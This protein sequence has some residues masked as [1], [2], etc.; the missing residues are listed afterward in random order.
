MTN[1]IGFPG[2]NLFFKIN[3]IAFYIGEK[4]VYWYGI[5]IAIGFLAAVA[6]V[7]S[8]CEKQGVKRDSIYDIAVWGL[9]FGVLGA[10]IYY[11]IFDFESIK[12]SFLN[13]FKIWNGGIAIYGGIIGACLSSYIYCRR[14]K[15]HTLKVFDVC[16]PGLLIGQIIGR[17][18]NFVNAEVYGKETSV[19]WRMT[20]NGDSGVHPLFLYESL[21]N[22]LGLFVVLTYRKKTDGE[23]FFLYMLWYALGRIWLEGMRQP[24]YILYLIPDKLGISQ[25]V[26]LIAIICS[27][28]AIVLLR[29]KNAN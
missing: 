12:G 21:W 16:A 22:L 29:K 7:A 5:I 19:L 20:I 18:G 25:L 26:S 3:R 10:R 28:V 15:L 11:V 6:F 4:P 2:L 17:F 24:Q 13:F 9:I 23:I 14:K 1:T 27:A 8:T